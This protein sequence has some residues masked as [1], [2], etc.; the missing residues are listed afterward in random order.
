M[1][2]TSA[3]GSWSDQLTYPEHQEDESVG[4][5]PDGN[6]NVFVMNVPTIAK[7]NITTSYQVEVEQPDLTGIRQLMAEQTTPLTVRY[8]LGSL[9]VRGNENE[10]IHVN[11]YNLAG[12]FVAQKEAQMNAGYVEVPVGD[13]STGCYLARIS[14]VHGNQTTCKFIQ[15]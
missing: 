14:G 11:I 2:L 3:D 7:A 13:L 4:R 6:N 10:R 5:Y 9:V 15:K 8:V 12:Q 1:I